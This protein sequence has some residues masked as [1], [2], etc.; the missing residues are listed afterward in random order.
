MYVH[1]HVAHTTNYNVDPA[2]FNFDK[3]NGKHPVHQESVQVR[4]NW[5]LKTVTYM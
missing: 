2:Y 3:I 1:V 4:E 5:E